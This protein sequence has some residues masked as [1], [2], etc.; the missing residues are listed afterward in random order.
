MV[1][2]RSR[3]VQWA[4]MIRNHSDM[5]RISLKEFQKM[6]NIFSQHIDV[7]YTN[8]ILLCHSYSDFEIL[9]KKN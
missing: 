7:T 2:K 5:V 4:N 3:L 8:D 6:M 1:R 9:Y